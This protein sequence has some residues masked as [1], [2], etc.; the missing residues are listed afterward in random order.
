MS[1]AR[2][3]REKILPGKIVYGTSLPYWVGLQGLTTREV[4]LGAIDTEGGGRL[5]A[6]RVSEACL[7]PVRKGRGLEGEKKETEVGVKVA[8]P[9]V[10]IRALTDHRLWAKS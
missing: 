1:T 5:R 8:R 6:Q 9:L 10:P 4:G 3:G 2:Y 7:V